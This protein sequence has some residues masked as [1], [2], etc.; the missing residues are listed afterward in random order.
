MYAIILTGGK[1]HKVKL[2]DTVKI[3]KVDADVATTITVNE[4]LMLADG[5]NVEWGTPYIAGQTVKAEVVEQGRSKKVHIIKFRR[6][7]NSMNRQGH[8][9]YYTEVKITEIGGKKADPKTMPDSAAAPEEQTKTKESGEAKPAASQKKATGTTKQS[10]EAVEKST[11]T[12]EKSAETAKP[13]VS[14]AVT[15]GKTAAK[16]EQKTKK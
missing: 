2:G 8:R 10:T 9:Q 5:E 4:V 1:Q 6:R 3:E 16:Q 15:A 14:K 12:V 7:K 11:E 13:T